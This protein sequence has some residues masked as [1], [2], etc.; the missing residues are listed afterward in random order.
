MTPAEFDQTTAT[1]VAP[2]KGGDAVFRATGRKLVFD[3]FMKVA[4]VSSEDQFSPSWPSSKMSSRSSSQPDAAFHAAPAAIHRSVAGEETRR[5]RHRPAQHL[6]QH[7][8]DDSGSRIRRADR[9]PLPRDHARHRRHRQTDP[10]V[11]RDHGREVHRR[12]GTRSSTRS[13]STISTGSNCC[14]ISTARSMPSSTA[15][16]TKSNT[17]AA[18]LALQM[19][20]M[21]QAD[22]LPHQQKWIFPQLLRLPRM[23]RHP[24]PSTSR[25]N[26]RS[27]KSANTNAPSA[28][29]R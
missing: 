24:S 1:I 4:G 17:P 5:T 8:P 28:A 7:H 20:Q 15:R 13:K 23:R 9:P 3:G 11:P 26:P 12:D 29:A 14:K 27:A 19:P 18:R 2:T 6:R 10:G 21:R 22:G 16:W 25:A